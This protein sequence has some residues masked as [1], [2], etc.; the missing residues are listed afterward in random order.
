MFQSVKK[1]IGVERIRLPVESVK[2][3]HFEAERYLG[4]IFEKAGKLMDMSVPGRTT[5]LPRDLAMALI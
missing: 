3:L 5:L 4:D 1:D 2:V